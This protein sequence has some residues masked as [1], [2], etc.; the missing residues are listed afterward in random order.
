MVDQPPSKYL[1]KNDPEN[2]QE[3]YEDEHGVVALPLGP[4]AMIANPSTN[5]GDSS[6]NQGGQSNGG[7]TIP[8]SIM[9]TSGRSNIQGARTSTSLGGQ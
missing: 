2:L 7:V 4:T 8:A 5:T 3:M 6:T 1:C 9:R